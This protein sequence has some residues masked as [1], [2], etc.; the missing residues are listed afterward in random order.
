MIFDPTA[1]A[2]E[3]IGV[4]IA[5][6]MFPLAI[7]LIAYNI[8]TIPQR[9]PGPRERTPPT[10]RDDVARS[11]SPAALLDAAL[12]TNE[13]IVANID[14]LNL[15]AIAIMALPVATFAFVAIDRFSHIGALGLFGSVL[16]FL[17]VL[18]G[19]LAY[20]AGYRDE[21]RRVLRESES[22]TRSRA[23]SDLEESLNIERFFAYY[24]IA[25]DVAVA[26]AIEQL[27]VVTNVN[28]RIRKRKVVLTRRSMALFASGL[29]FI[30]L[31]VWIGPWPFQRPLVTDPRGAF[32][33]SCTTGAGPRREMLLQCR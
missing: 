24:Q 28:G 12:R 17:S 6:L 31:G 27:N 10:A 22:T 7:V 3:R 8:M 19:W 30:L 20:D 18:F 33:F 29:T 2:G 16:L 11:L 13:T 26:E 25:G 23:P 21:A 9:S 15:G 14:T 4:T 5:I 1:T 32:N